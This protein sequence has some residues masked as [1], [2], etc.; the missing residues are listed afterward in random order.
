MGFWFFHP[1]V[2]TFSCKVG[3]FRLKSCGAWVD[4]RE[5]EWEGG[6]VQGPERAD[7]TGQ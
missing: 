3:L 4:R 1:K 5:E 2:R 7:L 6:L